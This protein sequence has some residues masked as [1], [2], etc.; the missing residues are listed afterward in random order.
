M[1]SPPQSECEHSPHASCHPT[2]PTPSS[3]VKATCT[4]CGPNQMGAG[5]TCPPLHAPQGQNPCL[6]HVSGSPVSPTVATGSST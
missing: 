2:T 1:R 6:I 3:K 4:L 5:Y